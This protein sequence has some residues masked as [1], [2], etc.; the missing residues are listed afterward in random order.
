MAC[1]SASGSVSVN[2]Q[3]HP[4][5]PT[6]ASMLPSVLLFVAGVCRRVLSLCPRVSAARREEPSL[7]MKDIEAAVMAPADSPNIAT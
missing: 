5:M 4:E 7:L 1:A 2:G 3:M 6:A